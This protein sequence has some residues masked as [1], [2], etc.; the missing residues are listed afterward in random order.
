MKKLLLILLLSQVAINISAQEDALLENLTSL[1]VENDNEQGTL[2]IQETIHDLVQNPINLNTSSEQQL[3]DCGLFSPYQVYGIIRYR[4]DMGNFFTI[5]EMASIPGFQKDKLKK[6]V[7]LLTFSNTELTNNRAGKGMILSNIYRKYPTSDAYHS[8]DSTQAIY[9]GSPFKISSRFK[10]NLGEKIMFGCAFEKDAGELAFNQWKPEHLIGYI[11]YSPGTFLKNITIGN[12]RLH[13]GIGLV[14]GLGFSSSGDGVQLNGFRTNFSKAFASTA[15]YS[16]YRGAIAEFTIK[17]WSITVYYSLKTEDISLFGINDST[18]IY[19]LLDA[20]RETGLHL[21]ASEQKG[22]DLAK[23]HSSGFSLNRDH[24]HFNYGISGSASTM[25]SGDALLDSIPF[26]ANAT[27]NS[28]NLSAYAIGY[29]EK[30]EV[31]A[32]YALNKTLSPALLIGWNFKLNP[33]LDSYGSFRYYHPDYTGQIPNSY[34]SGSNIENETGLNLGVLISPFDR[35]KIHL[36][37]DLCYMLS[38][39]YYLT[40]SGFKVRSKAELNYSFQNGPDVTVRYTFRQWYVDDA[41]NHPGVEIP[42]IKTKEQWRFHYSYPISESLK[43]TGRMEWAITDPYKFGFLIYQQ[44]QVKHNEWLSLT[45][46]ILL[47]D[48]D[49]WDNRIYCYEPGVRY[50]FLFPS[51]YGKGIRN[52]LVLSSKLSRW[53]TLRFRLGYMHYANKWKTG[54]GNDVRNGDQQLETEFQLQLSF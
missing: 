28:G 14:H 13:T 34:A 41:S 40:T 47:F 48:I 54:S 36:D 6:I 50:S 38:E 43:I 35:A 31:F 42:A 39:S 11:R 22:R 30:F 29:G 32:E 15:E 44:I 25:L 1:L 33:A 20:K 7:P 16:Y 10:Y 24:K 37:N 4:T 2:F 46:R 27:S 3:L 5:Y 49:S 21:T 23:Q 12:F 8:S 9:P 45:Y 26:L 51:Y 19:N 17:K 18:Q 52:S 53:V